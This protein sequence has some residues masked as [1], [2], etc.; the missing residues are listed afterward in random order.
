MNWRGYSIILNSKVNL[1]FLV[2]ILTVNISFGQSKILIVGTG[3]YPPFEFRNDSDSLIGFDIDLGNEIA[4]KL[5][6]KIIWKQLHFEQLFPSL[7]N[8]KVDFI[9]AAI[10]ETDKRKEKYLLSSPYLNTGLVFIA[11]KDSERKFR[12]SDFQNSKVAVKK[13]STGEEY[14]LSSKE[15]LHL[16]IYSFNETEECFNQLRL[17]KV[18][19]VISDYLSSRYYIKNKSQ[20]KS[21]KVDYRKADQF[22]ISTPPF[23]IAGLSIVAHKSDSNLMKEINKIIKELDNNGFIKLLFK[24]WLL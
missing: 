6:Y 3:Y 18:D 8:K 13:K 22:V 4:K 9:I 11:K 21:T 14:A 10:H 17:N 5:G 2:F 20:I 23:N 15:K 24:K 16:T 7:E 12:I 1:L 19:A